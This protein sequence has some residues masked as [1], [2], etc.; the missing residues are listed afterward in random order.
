[1]RSALNG[2]RRVREGGVLSTAV[3]TPATLCT[4]FAYFQVQ[5]QYRVVYFVKTAFFR[6]FC[7][8]GPLFFH[9]VGSGFLIGTPIPCN[10]ALLPIKQLYTP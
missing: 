1:M 4:A 8:L 5:G 6:S 9:T 2:K 7:L 3:R 10:A